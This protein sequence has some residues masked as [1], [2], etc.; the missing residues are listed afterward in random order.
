MY[1]YLY[2]VEI[3][4]V[5]VCLCTMRATKIWANKCDCD[6]GCFSSSGL[7]PSPTEYT[8]FGRR[9]GGD[10]CCVAMDGEPAEEWK[11]YV[12]WDSGGR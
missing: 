1:L 8:Y 10:G 9:L 4:F 11:S 2:I 7:W 3:L 5:S 12:W 6:C